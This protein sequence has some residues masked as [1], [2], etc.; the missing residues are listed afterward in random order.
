[1]GGASARI[2]DADGHVLEPAAMWREH[3]D[4]EFRERAPRVV[5]RE[6]GREDFVVDARVASR[7]GIN[8]IGALGVARV[9][10][11]E[12][13]RAGGFDP[14][15][16]LAD[17]DA[18][19][20]DAAVLYPTLGLL[21]GGIEGVDLYVALCRAYN[22]WLAAYC[23]KDPRRLFG[24]AMIPAASPAAAV[25][26]LR[27]AA[28]NLGYHAAFLRP[29]PWQ[30]RMIYDREWDPFWAAAQDLDV[31]VGIHEGLALN[32]PTVGADR[33]TNLMAQHVAS[34]TLE[35]QCASLGL[36]TC[37]VLERHPRLRVA[38]LESGG[39]WMMHWLHRIE[40]HFEN[41]AYRLSVPDMKRPPHEYFR[42]QC[43]VS[44]EPGEKTLPLHAE[45]C[46][47]ETILWA[48]D[49]PHPDGIFPGAVE[50]VRR[51]IAP[52]EGS[53]QSLV[54][55]GNARRLYALPG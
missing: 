33:F 10:R 48:S 27:F 32:L 55:G 7:F 2:I 40:E 12:E 3:V 44:F 34:H 54:L 1:M 19:G 5:R 50:R 29:N 47:A 4:P 8:R 37:G 11:Y 42:R 16:R 31:G 38:F 24:A 13:N 28:E 36:M 14:A 26:E 39:G 25:A 43:F 6:D 46:G 21:L 9:T 35:M 22:R 30:G 18:E 53:E 17:L 52:L 51:A 20:I 15:A 45:L 49:Y 23:A 41:R